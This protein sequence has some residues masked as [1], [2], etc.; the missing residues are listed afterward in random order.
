MRI[1]VAGGI[2]TP[3]LL[4][5]SEA[6]AILITDDAG[7]PNVIYK[8]LANGKGW[9]RLTEGEDKNFHSAAKDLGLI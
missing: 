9:I 3:I 7:R 6:T 5:T 8:L 4:D 1:V 2:K